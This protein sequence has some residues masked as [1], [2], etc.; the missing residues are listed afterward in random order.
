MR[1]FRSFSVYLLL[2]TGLAFG[3]S[4]N[5]TSVHDVVD[6]VSRRLSHE[7]EPDKVKKLDEAAILNFMTPNERQVLS[8]GFLFFEIDQ[9]ATVFIAVPG[10]SVPFWLA[11]QKF[12]SIGQTGKTAEDGEFS[13]WKKN[14]KAGEIGL[15]VNSL[16]GGGR[17]YWVLVQ[18]SGTLPVKI[19]E[20]YP[21]QLQTAIARKGIS[22][23]VDRESRIEELPA[24]LEGAQFIK[25]LHDHVDVAEMVG[26]LVTT[27][28]PG[29][30]QPDQI[31]L[32]WK[33]DPQTTQT[34]TWRTDTTITNAVVFYQEKNTTIS[35]F[36]KTPLVEKASTQKLVTRDVVGDPVVHRHTA[37]LQNL[38][39]RTTYVYSVSNAEKTVFSELYEF[40]T[41]PDITVPFSFLYLGDAQ[42]GFDRWGSLMRTA[43]QQRPDMAFILLAGDLVNRGAK[44][45]DWDDFFFNGT[46]QFARKPLM[47]TIGNH[48]CQGGHPTLYL[49]NF[50]LPLNGPAE[51]EPERAYHF[52][53]GNALV[54]VL[55]S[56]QPAEKQTAWLEDQLAQ[57][58]ATWKFVMFHHPIYSS[59]AT[60]NNAEIRDAWVP[61]FDKYHVDLVLQ[62][63]DHA[64]LR[65]FPMKNNQRVE[66]A[67]DGTIYV[68]AV[69]G[70]KMYDQ[71]EFD[72]KQ[73]GF[74]E[75]STFQ[76]LD[77][78]LSKNRLLYRSYNT[79][80]TKVDEFEIVK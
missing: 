1:Y 71:G 79:D 59:K 72:Y 19:S 2:F 43:Y 21:G 30:P 60:R 42:N 33:E 38:K 7:I 62:G 68:V 78:Q 18:P 39:P 64:Y 51:L 10:K 73:I 58:E 15:G 20:I 37:T 23:Y 17:H 54:V 41:A 36:P 25:T 66:T 61:V 53:Y 22:V 3:H 12:Q 69:S 27:K 57:S 14:F 56:N 80:G 34:I 9:P 26:M 76:I 28:Y 67:K 6:R 13:L 47:P 8:T 65:T 74:V 77:I 70:T 24:G 11:D 29:S 48:E 45:D 75:T 35:F 31:I 63:H 49:E 46:D 52:E 5:R 55:D 32:S 50:N 4:P 44:R 40:S 16:H